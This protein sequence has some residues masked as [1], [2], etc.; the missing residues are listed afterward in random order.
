MSLLLIAT[1]TKPLCTTRKKALLGISLLTGITSFFDISCRSPFC[2]VVMCPLPLLSC[3]GLEQ[4]SATPVPEISLSH[5][6]SAWDQPLINRDM[7]A[8]MEY[9]TSDYHQVRKQSS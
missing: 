9:T 4:W 1:Q 5:K 2:L 6:Q 3:F 8:L 7:T